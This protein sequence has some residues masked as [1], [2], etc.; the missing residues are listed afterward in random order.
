MNTN[1]ILES[2][3][4]AVIAGRSKDVEKGCR[5][6]LAA[7]LSAQDILDRS[8]LF[9]MTEV[10][11]RFS[12]GEFFIPEMLVAARAMKAGVQVLQ[13]ALG[14]VRMQGLGTVVLGTVLGD[15][16]DIG[17][18][19]AGIMLASAG[20]DVVDL[21]INVPGEKFVAAVAEKKAVAVGISALLT[22]TMVNMEPVVK[23]LRA[24]GFAGKIIIGGAPL[25]EEFARKIGADLY[26]PDA[27]E[28]A[29]KLKAALQAA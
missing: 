21:G 7:G 3:R 20:F 23:N 15:L 29:R 24:A 25:T 28:G 1:K 13:A 22:T 11:D 27:A 12:R 4:E 2:L 16:H 5:E 8:L 17:K 9:G 10:G 19:L 26:A 14:T 6:G 18:N